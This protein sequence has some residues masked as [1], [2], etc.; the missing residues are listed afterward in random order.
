M[1]L[2]CPSCH[3]RYLVPDAA[4]GPSGRQVRCASCR[5]SWFQ[6]PAQIDLPPVPEAAPAQAAP[7]EPAAPAPV[8]VA[9]PAPSA[10]T[11]PIAESDVVADYAP[12]ETA[13]VHDLPVVYRPRRSIGKLLLIVAAVVAIL[14]I[15]TVGAILAIGP[16]G[17][18]KSVGITPVAE[19][20]LLQAVRNP[21]RRDTA[22]GNALLAVTG[23]VLNPTDQVQTV[24]DIRAELRDP[25]GRTVYSWT[26]TRPVNELAPGASAQFDSAAVDVPRNATN[27]QLSFIGPTGN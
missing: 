26:I 12:P 18:R 22:S 23:K 16:D 21:E 1:I 8:S 15:A 3:T 9:A 25:Q 24:R 11:A 2:S 27:L 20:L 10:G 4:V 17:L 14:A 6:E 7:P 5:H 13:P 19:P